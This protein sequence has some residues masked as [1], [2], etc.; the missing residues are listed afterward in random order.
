[1]MNRADLFGLRLPELE[2][3]PGLPVPYFDGDDFTDTLAP[4][5]APRPCTAGGC[6]SGRT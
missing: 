1:M 6:R 5:R 2:Y 4:A 3:G